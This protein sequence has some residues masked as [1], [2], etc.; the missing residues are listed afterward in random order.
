MNKQQEWQIMNKIMELEQVM[1]SL[2]LSGIAQRIE[3]W[4]QDAAKQEWDYAEFLFRVLNDELGTRKEK[5]CESSIR[6]ARFPFIKTLNSFDFSYQKSINDKQIKEFAKARW[7]A[8]GF[9]K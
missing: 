1:F 6:T 4:L 7:V 9:C 8:N 5:R 3:T 2:K